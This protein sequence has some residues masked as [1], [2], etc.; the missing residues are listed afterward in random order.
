MA[1]LG[2]NTS[3]Q[4]KN[5]Y[6]SPYG[7]DVVDPSL[8]GNN[9]RPPPPTVSYPGQPGLGQ[10]IPQG[11]GQYGSPGP[12]QVQ[13][14][15]GTLGFPSQ[16]PRP[17]AAPTSGSLA[18]LHP[19]PTNWN[20]DTQ[21]GRK[22][23]P[24]QGWTEVQS[25]ADV[26]WDAGTNQYFYHGVPLTEGQF[27]NLYANGPGAM[28]PNQAQTSYLGSSDIQAN[29]A[30]LGFGRAYQPITAPQLGPV[31]MPQAMTVGAPP[32]IQAPT[33]QAEQGG[34]NNFDQLQ[35]SIYHSQYDPVSRELTR[36]GGLADE[37]LTAQL[38]QAGIAESGTGV[39]QRAQQAQEF[40][41]QDIAAAQDAA[42][43]ASV[44]RYGM[45]YT[46]SMDNAKM[47]QEANLANAG[48]S[49]QAQSENARNFLS[50]NIANAQLGTQASIA[51]AQIQSQQNIAQSQMYLQAMGINAQQEQASRS[52]YLQLLDLQQ[53]DL[54]H[55]DDYALE[56]LALFYNTYL[57]QVSIMVQAGAA[58][59]GKNDQT[60]SQF[61]LD[62]GVSFN[63]INILGN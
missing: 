30:N 25:G 28:N 6:L 1:T 37:K 62:T 53:K 21:P 19:Y 59:F 10:P 43:K 54:Q 58:S 42:N 36:Q 7:N 49:I 41:R 60:Q 24:N 52:N 56:N 33:V 63:P 26:T 32:T 2:F 20:P 4:Q 18:T 3:V 51:G 61:N 57:K 35:N 48:F 15:N 8:Y 44:Q 16:Q 46:Q 27:A 13:P 45:E 34:F 11:P 5:P 47:R 50:A 29:L 40:Q 39:A 9:Y 38:A 23:V 12:G 31:Q 14:T 17:G 55:M 22:Y